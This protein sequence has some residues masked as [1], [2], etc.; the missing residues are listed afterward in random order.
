VLKPPA[1]PLPASS[2]KWRSLN[3]SGLK[4]SPFSKKPFA[5]LDKQD[6]S[7]LLTQSEAI[8]QQLPLHMAQHGFVKL[9]HLPQTQ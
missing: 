2:H 1:K 6:S 4:G 9:L 7:L 3:A 8:S 5:Q